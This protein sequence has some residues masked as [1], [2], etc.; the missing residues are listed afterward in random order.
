V[1]VGD[2]VFAFRGDRRWLGDQVHADD[3]DGL[4]LQ[5]LHGV[6]GADPDGPLAAA[7]A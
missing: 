2:G 6:H 5:A 4:E 7:A 3:R 1:G